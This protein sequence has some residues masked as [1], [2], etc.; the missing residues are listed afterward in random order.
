MLFRFIITLT[1]QFTAA[2][3]FDAGRFLCK[4]AQWDSMPT[5]MAANPEIV[6]ALFEKKLAQGL[7][8]LHIGFSSGLSSSYN[9][10]A[11]VGRELCDEH[12]EAK[13]IVIDSLCASL[14][15]GLLV[16]KA[17]MLKKAGKSIEEISQWLEENKLHLCHQFT[18][19]DLFHLHRGR[20][21][22]Q[23]N[24]NSGDNYQRE[25]GAPCG[26]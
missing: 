18:V 23:G 1:V 26:R 10:A 7:D 15:E 11:V 13:I 3:E 25:T 8:I 19:D 14:G 4:D 20:P 5:T 16:H 6:R 9:A 21:R 2:I 22:L 24:C 17:V 12:S